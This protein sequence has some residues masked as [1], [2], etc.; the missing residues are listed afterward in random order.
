MVMP[1]TLKITDPRM[2]KSIRVKKAVKEPFQA[3]FI[4]SCFENRSVIT[5][6]R[7]AIP[8][9]LIRVNKVVRQKMKNWV[10]D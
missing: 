5:R 1:K 8:M 3:M 7:G 10:S 6:R 9:G 2:E 4:F